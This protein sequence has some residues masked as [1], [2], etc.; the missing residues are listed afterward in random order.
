MRSHS[1]LLSLRN[2]VQVTTESL[3]IGQPTR[4]C[5]PSKVLG[6]GSGTP[7]PAGHSVVK[8]ACHKLLLIKLHCCTSMRLDA[9][10][11]LPCA[12][13]PQ[14]CRQVI[15]PFKRKTERLVRKHWR[16]KINLQSTVFLKKN[17]VVTS[18]STPL[19]SRENQST[20]RVTRCTESPKCCQQH[21]HWMQTFRFSPFPLTF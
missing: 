8:G 19:Y 12:H 10:N 3:G 13:I 21:G 7:F 20:E 14:F 5:V 11:A 16:R 4:P 6:P 9:I 2:E 18:S 1:W 17:S 15:W